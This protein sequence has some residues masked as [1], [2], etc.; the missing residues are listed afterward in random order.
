MSMQKGAISAKKNSGSDDVVNSSVFKLAWP[1][2]VQA[3]LSM[4][5]GYIDTLMLSGYDQTAV[6][7]IGNAN[8]ILRIENVIRKILQI[9]DCH[10]VHMMHDDLLRNLISF[11]T[12]IAPIVTN[13][14]LITKSSPF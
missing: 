2:F 13:D 10:R 4:L 11:K 8:Q 1:I 9:V 3:L 7:A 6:G 12:K 14:D 5:L